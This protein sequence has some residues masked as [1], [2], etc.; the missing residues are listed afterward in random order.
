MKLVFKQSQMD[1]LKEMLVNNPDAVG[2]RLTH[3]EYV[4]IMDDLVQERNP[5]C[6]LI[7]HAGNRKLHI[8]TRWI[9]VEVT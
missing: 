5:N 3:E 4:S 2:V 1:I 8:G 9:A 6:V 7:S